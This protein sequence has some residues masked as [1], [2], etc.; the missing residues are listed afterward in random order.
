MMGSL[1]MHAAVI[2]V[3]VF[4][5]VQAH[6]T[7]E[8]IDQSVEVRLAAPAPPPLPEPE[9]TP[10]AVPPPAPVPRVERAKPP[11]A[12]K[13]PPAGPKDAAPPPRVVGLSLESTVEGGE[14]PGFA[15]GNTALGRTADRAVAPEAVARSG[16]ATDAARASNA[17]ATRIPSAGVR[18]AMPQ[19]KRVINPVYPELLKSQGIEADVTVMLS[20]DASG[21]VAGVKIVKPAPY[22]EFNEAAR[23]A[24]LAEQFLPATRDGIAIP[25]S[26]SFTYRFRLEDS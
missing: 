12:P 1:A 2:A 25:Y 16:L 3:G 26:L 6:G 21:A 10:L 9:K 7:R 24:A 19:R 4:S 17:V 15:V 8:T 18:Y 14:G 20:L 22:P 11:P 23:K 13:P 5:S